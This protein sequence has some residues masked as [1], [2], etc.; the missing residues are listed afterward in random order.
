MNKDFNAAMF[1]P[2]VALAA[3][4][5]EYEARLKAIATEWACYKEFLQAKYPV[6]PIGLW[7][8]TCPYHKK[9]DE[10]CQEEL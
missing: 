3:K 4:C 2:E 8:F 10:L 7:E 6:V 9:L 5:Q 1:G